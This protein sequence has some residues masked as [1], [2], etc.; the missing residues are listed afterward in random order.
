HET[1]E[2]VI[3]TELASSNERAVVACISETQ[4]E[5]TVVNATLPPSSTEVAADVEPS[6][7]KRRRHIDWRRCIDRRRRRHLSGIRGHRSC[8][9]YRKCC[10]R[11]D[12]LRHNRSPNFGSASPQRSYYRH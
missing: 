2:L 4:A 6:P 12:Q 5:E 7:T 1:A 3:E 11:M 8:Q 10:R 9:Q